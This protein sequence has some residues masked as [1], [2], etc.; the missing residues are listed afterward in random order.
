VGWIKD[1]KKAMYNKVYRKTTFGVSDLADAASAAG[2]KKRVG[3]RQHTGHK[4]HAGCFTWLASILALAFLG[5]LIIG[6]LSSRAAEG[7]DSDSMARGLQNTDSAA[8]ESQNADSAALEIQLLDVGQGT[9]VLFQSDGHALL[10]DGGGSERSSFVVSFLQQ[11]GIEKLDAVIATHYDDDHI[12]GLIGVIYAFDCGAV[13]APDYEEESNTR[14]SFEKAIDYTRTPLYHPT[15]GDTI[16]FGEAQAEILRCDPSAEMENNR[17][18]VTRVRG[19]GVT[20]LYAGDLEAEGEAA[21]LSSRHDSAAGI[22]ADSAAGNSSDSTEDSAAGISADS[23]AGNFAD[24]TADSATDLA[25]D[26]YIVSHHGSASSS[27]EAFLQAISPTYA[28]LSCGTVNDY[29]FP[30]A[31][32]LTR[33]QAHGCHLYRT[34]LQGT[35]TL[36]CRGGAV[37]AEASTPESTDWSTG[38]DIAAAATRARDGDGLPADRITYVCNTNSRKF[39]RPDCKNVAAINAHNRLDTDQ[40]AEELMQQGYEPCGWCKPG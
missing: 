34:D 24:S 9:A 10:I 39:H 20:A 30:H 22:A 5:V 8:P 11:Q 16:T 33:L 12:S 36:T 23:T 28:L 15:A 17:S 38:D 35:V 4:R 7:T 13:I 29:G 3:R 27:S 25:A 31:T 21:L 40:T 18:I 6:A 1:P 26:I 14:T 37:L 32:V 2:G 19:G